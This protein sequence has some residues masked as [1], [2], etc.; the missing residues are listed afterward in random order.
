MIL[1]QFPIGVDVSKAT[2]DIFDSQSARFTQIENQPSAIAAWRA[3]LDPRRLIIFE[4]TSVVDQAL[5]KDLE[6]NNHPFVRVNPRD[7]RDFARA[8]G[9]RAKTDRVDARMLAHMAAALKPE[10][11]RPRCGL[12]LRLSGFLSRRRQLVEMR[13]QERTR[14][15]QA[16]DDT[17]L[18]SQ[19][20]Q[21]LDVLT[22][23]IKEVEAEIEALVHTDTILDEAYDRLKSA[24]GIGPI[25]AATLIA[26]LPELGLRDRRQIASL[27]GLA[28]HPRDSGACKGKRTIWGG[29]KHIRD[30][31][32]GAA[33]ST[34]RSKTPAAER[35]KQ[36]LERGKQKK[37]AI[38]AIAR[39]MLVAINAMMK[40]Q[41]QWDAKAAVTLAS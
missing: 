32:F 12:R 40:K 6:A 22:A 39:W 17:W 29:R 3:D 34:I 41:T 21:M 30:L 28:P 24:P 2:L 35:Y 5:H 10:P 16:G 7:A 25:T 26:D 8:S 37:C 9:R 4:A 27:V 11:S 15:K 33:V 23:Q 36:L 1:H 38:V 19:I 13:K 18:A 14:I 31:M 20:N